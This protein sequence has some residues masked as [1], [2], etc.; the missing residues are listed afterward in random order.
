MAMTMKGIYLEPLISYKVLPRTFISSHEDP[1]MTCHWPH[2][3]GGEVKSSWRP[4][5]CPGFHRPGDVGPTLKVTSAQGPLGPHAA[6]EGIRAE[7]GSAASA[8]PRT[9][10]VPG[11]QYGS[12]SPGSQGSFKCPH[13]SP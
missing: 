12:E 9:G 3:K 8:L 5:T 7:A 1:G 4:G 6:D 10:N 2:L 11:L 13:Q